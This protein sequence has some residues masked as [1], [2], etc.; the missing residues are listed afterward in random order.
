MDPDDPINELI[1]QERRQATDAYMIEVLTAAN[2]ALIA[3]VEHHRS[4]LSGAK[5][6]CGL[7]AGLLI[8]SW[9]S[10]AIWRQ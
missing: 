4:L 6:L 7:L 9:V 2:H 8:G 5:M 1:A 10:F 3:Q